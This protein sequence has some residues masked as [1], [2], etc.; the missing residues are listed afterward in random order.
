[1][2]QHSAAER[3]AD[4]QADRPA[5]LDDAERLLLALVPLQRADLAFTTGTEA[6][7]VG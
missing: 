6:A 3:A 7:P 5:A 4:R 2:C 1:V